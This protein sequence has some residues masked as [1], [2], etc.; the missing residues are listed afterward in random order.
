MSPYDRLC[1]PDP[2]SR[3][4]IQE[5]SFLGENSMTCMRRTPRQSRKRHS[6]NRCSVQNRGGDSWTST[7]GASTASER[8]G[9]ATAGRLTAL[10]QRMSDEAF[11][12]VGGDG[13]DSL[14]ARTVATVAS[15]LRRWS[16]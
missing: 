15:L 5:E 6:T 12:K 7:G 9:T 2:G 8:A 4:R 1:E 10:V 16:A 3:R 14:R 11:Q 13:G